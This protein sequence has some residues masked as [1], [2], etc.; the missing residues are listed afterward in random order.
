[1]S[2][3]NGNVLA[4]LD[5]A[6]DP[7][8][9]DEVIATD[10]EAAG[11]DLEP[12]KLTRLEVLE[13]STFTREQALS[14]VGMYYSAQKLRV[15]AG[16]R[17]SAHERSVDV[18]SD[19][20][21]VR[22]LKADLE[23][24]EKQAAR[25]LKAFAE[26]QLLGR[27]ALSQV[28]VGP[29]I[30][31]GLLAHIDLK[32]CACPVYRGMRAQDRPPHVC[33]GVVTAGAVWRFAGLDPTMTWE[34]G[35]KRPYNAKLKRL[36]WI[37]GEC[38]KKTCNNE[39]A[40]YGRLYR[41]RKKLEVQRNEA[42]DFRALALE[43]LALANRNRYRISPEQREIWG[44]GKLQAVGLD[45]RAARYAVKI[46]LSHLHQ[47]GRE[48]LFGECV[49]PWVLVHGQGHAHFIAPPN[50]PLV[51]VEKKKRG[52]DAPAPETNGTA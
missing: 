32:T 2:E 33:P 45:R 5:R 31:A 14:L 50:W 20:N 3:T 6:A 41:E 49:K 4:E 44:S 17:I 11:G 51:E 34:K 35:E 9:L 24:I 43:R 48:I 23:K 16:N 39:K 26:S 7:T 10:A 25:G 27:W 13:A 30:A 18:L 29:V 28:G 19:S 42:G 15:G 47:V 40:F 12:R 1:M 21:L 37:L 46:F 22:L 8:P 38:F 36:C 52:A